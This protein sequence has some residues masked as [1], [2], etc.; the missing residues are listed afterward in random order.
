MILVA[1]PKFQKFIARRQSTPV[2]IDNSA[3]ASS[4]F[5]QFSK[6]PSRT[7][8]KDRVVR[9]KPTLDETNDLLRN[10]IIP[11]VE[12][13]DVS[14]G[15]A[16]SKIRL[17]IQDSGIETHQF[18][19][20]CDM[21]APYSRLRIKDLRL[22]E[23]P[24]AM[25]FKYLCD[26]TILRYRVRPGILEFNSMSEGFEETNFD[27]STPLAEPESAKSPLDPNDPFSGIPHEIEG[28]D[29]FAEP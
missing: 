12:I 8:S 25:V 4:D 22:R 28:P 1:L 7:K 21:S 5:A 27:E 2:P 6:L 13:G 14:V 10:T 11:L 29:P 15:E 9:R 26:S 16:V 19:I 18:R 17:L 23:V 20:V 24:L 3:T